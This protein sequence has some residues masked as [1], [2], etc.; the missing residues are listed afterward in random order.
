MSR[1][2]PQR[3]IGGEDNLARRIER[4][5]TARGWSYETLAKKMTDAGCSIQGSAIYKIE[6]AD[7]PRRITVDELMALATVF[8]KSIEN[9]L[10][11]IEALD[12]ARAK[13][14]LVDLDEADKDLS[15]AVFMVHA[16]HEKLF[17]LASD[18]PELFEYVKGHRDRSR[19][20]AI[21]G[22]RASGGDAP[23]FH[24]R[25]GFDAFYQGLVEHAQWLAE[26]SLENQRMVAELKGPLG[27]ALREVES[28]AAERAERSS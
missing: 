10:T 12:Q 21:E 23:T 26:L 25:V 15:M 1:L 16:L 17:E 20:A 5:R 19:S 13:Q 28:R 18:D 4:E 3:S 24:E 8:G 11:P 27:I 6:K 2:N 7:P 22:G 9:L 14:L